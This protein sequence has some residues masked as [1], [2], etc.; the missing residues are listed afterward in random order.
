MKALVV[1]ASNSGNT[2]M[3]AER[4]GQRLEEHKIKATVRDVADMKP[5]DL[6]GYDLIVFGSCTWERFVDGQRLQAQ[7]PEHMHRFVSS[8]EHT[9]LPDSKFAVFALG[10]HEYTGFAG[11]AA[12]LQVLV[13]KL[14]GT[15][16]IPPLKIDGFPHHQLELADV[17]TDQ[18]VTNVKSDAAPAR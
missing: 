13:H 7:L 15:E 17:W 16:S 9:R 14:G 18:L 1:Y 4:I 5:H 6:R 8:A 10:R 12:H 2:R 3:V 11:A